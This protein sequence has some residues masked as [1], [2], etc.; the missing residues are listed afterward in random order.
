MALSYT[1]PGDSK[2]NIKGEDP[3]LFLQF[4]LELAKQVQEKL[5][6]AVEELEA[7]EAFM[8]E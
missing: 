1:L 2:I 4:N 3:T 6:E 5:I 7:E 8:E